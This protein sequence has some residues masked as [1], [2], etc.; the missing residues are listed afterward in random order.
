MDSNLTKLTVNL[1]RPAVKALELAATITGDTKTDTVNR[2]IQLYAFL[3][4]AEAEGRATYLG[5]L[6][7]EAG[8]EQVKVL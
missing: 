8:L 7:G 4:A 3:A 2:A 6:P 1:V 5:G